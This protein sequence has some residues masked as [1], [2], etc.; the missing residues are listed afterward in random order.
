MPFFLIF[1]RLVSFQMRLS[2]KQRAEEQ[3]AILEKQRHLEEVLRQKRELENKANAESITD[4]E[5]VD[6]VFGFLP[7]IVVGGQEGQAPVGFE[8][9]WWKVQHVLTSVQD[10]SL[11]ACLYLF[12]N[13][14]KQRMI[15]EEIDIDDISMDEELPQDDFDDLDEYSFSKF[16]S[17]YFQGAA[18]PTHIRQRLQQPLLY[19]EDAADVLVILLDQFN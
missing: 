3:R 19:H 11:T 13:L 2:A 15:T 14:E 10:Q 5:M 1:S 17:M 12:Q 16:A 7:A 6:S 18:S 8:V 4:Q 9:R